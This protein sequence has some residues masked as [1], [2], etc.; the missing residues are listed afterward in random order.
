MVSAIQQCKSAIIILMSPPSWASL[1]SQQPTLRSSESTWAPCVIA[2]SHK[3][4]VL[5]M[6]VYIYGASLVAQRVKRL[7]TVRET[8]VLSLGRE[9]F[10][11]EGNSN[12]LQYSR[13]E[14]PMDRGAWGLQS[15]GSQRVGRDWATSLHF[16]VYMSLLLSPLVSLSPSPTMT[17]SLFSI[18]VSQPYVFFF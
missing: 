16:S 4:S 13:L 3:L 10:P 14:N 11:G 18:S 15:M 5:H 12:P 8:R 1:P 7:P 9:D 6:G 17:T 2:A